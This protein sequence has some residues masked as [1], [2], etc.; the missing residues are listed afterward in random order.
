MKIKRYTVAEAQENFVG[1]IREAERGEDVYIVD[2]EKHTV[3][4][5]PLSEGKKR[6]LGGFE[7]NVSWTP[8]A[9]DPLTD[10]ELKDWGLE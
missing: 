6:K 5:V 4:L 1:L 8:D 3:K 2:D 7:G 10:E 9:F